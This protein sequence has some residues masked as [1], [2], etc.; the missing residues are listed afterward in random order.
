MKLFESI[1]MAESILNEYATDLGLGMSLSGKNNSGKNGKSSDSIAAGK[2]KAYSND[3]YLTAWEQKLPNLARITQ[4]LKKDRPES[5][6]TV[7]GPALEELAVLVK[8]KRPLKKDKEGLYILPMG[9]NIRLVDI[10]GTFML[11]YVGPDIT[12]DREEKVEPTST[13]EKNDKELLP[14]LA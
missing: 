7:F 14:D 3:L 2:A 5:A 6:L 10:G 12:N 9:D 8:A 4:K 11:K 1:R 13:T